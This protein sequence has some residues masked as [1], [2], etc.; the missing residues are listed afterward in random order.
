MG[1]LETTENLPTVECEGPIGSLHWLRSEPLAPT[2]DHAFD[3]MFERVFHEIESLCRRD[4]KDIARFK[5]FAR[6]KVLDMASVT[7]S[8]KLDCLQI[9][10][11]YH[12][13]R[14]CRNFYDEKYR[15]AKAERGDNRRCS[16]FTFLYRHLNFK[17]KSEMTKH[18]TLSR[19]FQSGRV[20][21]KYR[22]VIH[23]LGTDRLQ[24]IDSDSEAGQ[25]I[26]ST[27]P[28]S[29]PE[30]LAMMKEFIG[31]NREA[32]R[33]LLELSSRDLATTS[34]NFRSAVFSVKRL[35]RSLEMDAEV[36]TRAV[37]GLFSLE[38]LNV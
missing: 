9:L 37:Y 14:G 5:P 36:F 3:E 30:R 32:L 6:S 2:K 16:L 15:L 28:S 19:A 7:Q 13:F 26:A 35:A 25:N 33:P 21:S 10:V 8:D 12:L 34:S 38:T 4:W 29:N 1:K 22:D 24:A 18:F 27:D 31:Q 17:Y 20:W 11:S 23:T